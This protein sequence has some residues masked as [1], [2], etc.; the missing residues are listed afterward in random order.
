MISQLINEYNQ[1][2]SIE[3]SPKF[4]FFICDTKEAFLMNIV[5]SLWACEK[6]TEGFRAFGK[7]ISV[8]TKIDKMSE[9]LEEKLKQLGLSGDFSSAFSSINI[10]DVTWPAEEPKSDFT[11]QKMF[12][13]LRHSSAQSGNEISSSYVSVLKEPI[14]VHW[15]TGTP[16]PNE[17]VFK[18]FIF[19][20]NAKISPVTA[21]K[22]G[23]NETLLR[24]LHATR[25]W[26][27]VG[28]LLKTLEKSCV[29]ELEA[30]AFDSAPTSE[31]DELLKDCVESELKFYR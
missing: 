4:G 14:S 11:A 27:E 9:D 30:L 8:M 10:S 23:D 7:G 13:I 29:D 31:L 25:K 18:P 22:D 21:I 19:T 28:E 12:E 5:G 24:K 6:I 16:N 26:D 3:T 15:F 1:D 2:G 20:S 17:S